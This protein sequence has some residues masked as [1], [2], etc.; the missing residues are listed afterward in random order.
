MSQ[1]YVSLACG[2]SFVYD[3]VQGWGLRCKQKVKLDSF[4]VKFR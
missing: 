1:K 2:V 4:N 3:G